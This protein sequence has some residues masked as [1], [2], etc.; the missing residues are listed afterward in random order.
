MW[1]FYALIA[2][3]LT[4]AAGVVRGVARPLYLG[5]F[6]AAA[7]AGLI[8][9]WVVVSTNDEGDVVSSIGPESIT[10]LVVGDDDLLRALAAAFVLL[11]TLWFGTL[12]ASRL[13]EPVADEEQVTV[14][15]R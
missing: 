11:A 9:A 3:G 13:A 4:V 14:T 6:V 5:A 7:I 15:S 1:S 10:G 12:A 2:L 8:S